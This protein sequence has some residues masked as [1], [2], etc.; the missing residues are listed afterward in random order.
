[1][2]QPTR[3]RPVYQ[4]PYCCIVV[5]CC[6]V[7]MPIQG[8][9]LL[10][11]REKLASLTAVLWFSPDASPGEISCMLSNTTYVQILIWLSVRL[12]RQI[13]AV[14]HRAHRRLTAG[15]VNCCKQSA[16]LGTC[17]SQSSSV[18]LTT[19]R[20]NRRR[21]SFSHRSAIFLRLFA[22]HSGMERRSLTGELSLSCARLTGYSWAG[23]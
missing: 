6:V 12:W 8:L 23:G 22:W 13:T 11:D 20:S 16:T 4:S 15:V 21:A 18:L 3:Q 19:P 5:R 9:K 1:M 7:L 2:Q 14:V 17:C 10:F